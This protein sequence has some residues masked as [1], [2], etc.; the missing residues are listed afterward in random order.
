MVVILIMNANL[1]FY[2]DDEIQELVLTL[3]LYIFLNILDKM[4]CHQ[5]TKQE[6]TGFKRLSYAAMEAIAPASIQPG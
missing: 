6:Q 5:G 2:A 4:V 1:M 3:V